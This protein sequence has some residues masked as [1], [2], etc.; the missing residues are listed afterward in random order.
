MDFSMDSI[1]PL[2][3]GTRVYL[4]TRSSDHFWNYDPAKNEF[5]WLEYSE[6]PSPLYDLGDAKT[7][8]IGDEAYVIKGYTENASLLWSFNPNF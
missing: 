2:E 8:V 5:V 6:V 1:Y 4:T 7:F 3:L